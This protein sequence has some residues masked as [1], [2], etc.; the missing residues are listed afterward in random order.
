MHT[1]YYTLYVHW[2]DGV[3][4][5]GGW[6][7]EREDKCT[8]NPPP[9]LAD[10]KCVSNGYG[11]CRRLQGVDEHSGRSLPVF[12]ATPVCELAGLQQ[13]QTGAD[14][15]PTLGLEDKLRLWSTT[16]RC[17]TTTE[18]F[19]ALRNAKFDPAFW[20]E[21]SATDTLRYDYKSFHAAGESDGEADAGNGVWTSFLSSSSLSC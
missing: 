7:G 3:D 20:R 12:L 2:Q 6:S 21:I 15:A 14:Q 4:A 18:L 9:P 16:G 17:C 19:D 10:A 11:A 1:P 8:P 5:N 13:E